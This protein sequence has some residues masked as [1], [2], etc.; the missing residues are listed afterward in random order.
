MRVNE[1]GILG[2]GGYIGK[3]ATE[4]LLR[5]GFHV[6]GA[7]RKEPQN[8]EINDNF[9]FVTVDVKDKQQ[10]DTFIQSCNIVVNCISP[11]YLYGKLVKDAVCEQNKIYVDPSDMS[12]E[13]DGESVTG[14]CV[15]SCGYIPGMAEFFPYILFQQNFDEIERIIA[16]QGGFDGCSPGAFVDMILG[17]GNK[18]L[19]GDAYILN[20]KITPL[21]TDFKKT[22]KIPFTQ[23]KVIFKPVINQDSV[24]LQK[25]INSKEHYF[26]C[27]YDNMETLS[28]FM[29]LLIEVAR[30]DK[31][32]AAE[33]IEKKLYE[34]IKTDKTFGKE[35]VG[36]YL[37]F[38]LA[39]K[40]G[41]EEKTIVGEIFLKNVNR[42]CG[43]FL[44]EVVKQISMNQQHISEGINYAFEILNAE[45]S[46][47][48]L[49]ELEE[50]EYIKIVE[51]PTQERID[52]HKILYKKE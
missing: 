52:I 6:N 48:I 23:E 27:T 1:I 22:Y 10:L 29:K 7:Q 40:K 4:K 28:F 47:E 33:N 44:G 21:S 12:F 14:R 38:E 49:E 18:N 43:N 15:A 37:F 36:A 51:I 9:R 42:L 41:K 46:R 26:F 3:Y 17:A 30:Y 35:T 13:K 20:G 25:K 8:I 2:C 24:M 32:T 5:L 31:N 50:G 16:Y 11:S 19:H 34:K 39:G 45:Y